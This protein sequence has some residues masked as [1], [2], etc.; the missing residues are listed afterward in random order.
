MGIFRISR[1]LQFGI[2]NHSEV[3]E[4]PHMASAEH[5]YG[6]KGSWESHSKQRVHAFHRLSSCQERRGNLSSCWAF[7][8]GR[9]WELPLQVSQLYLTEVS[10]LFHFI[11][12]CFSGL[13][14]RHMELPRLRVESELQLPAT[15]TARAMQDPSCICDLHH[16]SL[17]C[18]IPDPLSEARDWTH[19]LM[20]P[21]W[22]RSCWATMGTPL[23][24]L[25]TAYISF[26]YELDIIAIPIFCLFC[27]N[28]ILFLTMCFYLVLF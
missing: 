19:I 1:E 4:R 22:I 3:C 6:G 12:F 25:H 10:I 28:E 15:I 8:H 2:R 14:P 17:Q 7:Y 13:H 23:I 21:S 27:S 26:P 16:S 5:F 20:D 9:A 18:W 11:S 24:C